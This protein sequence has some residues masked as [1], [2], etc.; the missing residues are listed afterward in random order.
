MCAHQ[1]HMMR[2]AQMRGAANNCQ[3]CIERA[4]KNT[5]SV[6]IIIVNFFIVFQFSSC[7]FKSLCSKNVNGM[8]KKEVVV[9]VWKWFYFFIVSVVV[10]NDNVSNQYRLLTEQKHVTVVSLLLMCN[11]SSSTFFCVKLLTWKAVKVIE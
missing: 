7:L 8:C 3:L 10:Q 5:S 4:R 6:T 1:P 2:L 11:F 9:I